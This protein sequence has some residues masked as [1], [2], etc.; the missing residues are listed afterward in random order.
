MISF[1]RENFYIHCPV[2]PVRMYL[3]LKD[4]DDMMT[5]GFTCEQCEFEKT[6]TR[7]PEGAEL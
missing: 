5:F 4:P 7:W 1:D 6:N 3:R 2:H